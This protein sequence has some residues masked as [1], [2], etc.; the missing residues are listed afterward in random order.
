M[1]AAEEQQKN[2]DQ[3]LAII[4][5]QQA[6]IE[7]LHKHLPELAQSLFKESLNDARTSIESD[8]NNHATKTAEE[9]KKPLAGQ[10]V[11]LTP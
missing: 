9:L 8:L 11:Q 7:S 2:I 10:C 6:E 1:A 4:N 3:T 5:K